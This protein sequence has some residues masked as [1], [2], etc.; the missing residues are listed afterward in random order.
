[1]NSAIWV[2]LLMPFILSA[3]TLIVSRLAP[4]EE[5]QTN[6]SKE[7]LRSEYFKWY[8]G[9]TGFYLLITVVF[10]CI[11][12]FL[13]SFLGELRI[14]GFTPAVFE[15]SAC[16]VMWFLPCL[17]LGLLTALAP[18]FLIMRKL[19]QGRYDEYW[20]Y[21]DQI[22]KYST[23]R[24][25]PYVVWGTAIFSSGMLLVCFQHYARFSENE[26]LINRVA[27]ISVDKYVLDDIHELA[28][29]LNVKVGIR[30]N[31]KKYDPHYRILFKDNTEWSTKDSM[32]CIAKDNYV[33]LFDYLEEKTGLMVI[34]KEY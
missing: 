19:L 29:I 16:G 21:H 1:M 12:Y 5:Y 28:Y 25:L 11:Y 17:F 34:E 4:I 33:S 30:R 15:Y 31:Q 13:F 8:L 22:H 26:I 7:E 18:S 3:I 23:K 2:S 32:F 20:Y 24:L 6:K 14:S 27:Q 10:V 9:S